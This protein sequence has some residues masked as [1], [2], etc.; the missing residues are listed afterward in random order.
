MLLKTA[1]TGRCSDINSKMAEDRWYLCVRRYA[2]FVS[3]HDTG[4]LYIDLRKDTIYVD[5]G[6]S[7]MNIYLSKSYYDII[8]KSD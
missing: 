5:N 6:W 1:L 7:L 2:L 3:D 8:D 4:S